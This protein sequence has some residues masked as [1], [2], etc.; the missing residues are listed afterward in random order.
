LTAMSSLYK[1]N[2]TE[3]I[4]PRKEPVLEL[5]KVFSHD[6]RSHLVSVGA[7]LALLEKGFYGTLSGKARKET[8]KVSQRV[9]KMIE[10]LEDVIAQA[11]A[12][13][14][15]A[16]LQTEPVDLIRDIL[17]PLLQELDPDIP[18]ERIFVISNPPTLINENGSQIQ[19]NRFLLK[20]VLRNLIRNAD[21]YGA[22]QGSIELRI[23]QM[24]RYLIVDVGNQRHPIAEEHQ[25]DLF[26]KSG[27]AG[28]GAHRVKH[29]LGIGLSLIK[30]I[31]GSHGGRI[32]YKVDRDTS[33][34]L[35]S[36]PTSI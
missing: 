22:K 11:L 31:V 21:A 28:S 36:L 18:R 15:Q 2:L 8:R 20:S 25:R 14:G 16:G 7:A 30:R 4:P 13:E 26:T 5:L 19:G 10:M 3:N 33:H 35:F 29:G 9:G 34:F 12:L 27:R 6:C 32:W 1:Q 24:D 23:T 17:K